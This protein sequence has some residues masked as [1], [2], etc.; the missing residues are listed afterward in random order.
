MVSSVA[1]LAVVQVCSSSSTVLCRIYASSYKG[2]QSAE[3]AVGL[4]I[5][6]DNKLGESK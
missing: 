3:G 2:N 6:R 5:T 1:K 4:G